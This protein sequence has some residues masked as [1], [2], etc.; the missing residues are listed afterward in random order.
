MDDLPEYLEWY[1]SS[2]APGTDG[3]P[4]F[5]AA[6]AELR[7]CRD[8]VANERAGIVA[9]L[10]REAANDGGLVYGNYHHAADAIEA[11]QDKEQE[12]SA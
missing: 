4:R 7:S 11:Q 12:Q 3:P 2:I 9:W 10:R 5:L 8:K 6:A 1:A